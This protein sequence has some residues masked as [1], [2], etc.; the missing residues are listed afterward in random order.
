MKINIK[1]HELLKE[2]HEILEEFIFMN[3]QCLGRKNLVEYK[4]KLYK[5]LKV[6]EP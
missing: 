3:R 2:A 5:F 1:M 6:L 4:D